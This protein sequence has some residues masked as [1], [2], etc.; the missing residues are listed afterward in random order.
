M[1]TT[2]QIKKVKLALFDFDGVF[3]DNYVYVNQDG[4]E[5]VRCNRSDG[6]GLARLRSLDIKS[7]IVS[8]E[9]NPVVSVRAKKLNI[10]CIQGVSDKSKAVL[11]ICNDCDINPEEALFVGNDINDL[12]ALKIVGLAVAV[13]DA[14]PEILP[15]VDYITEKNGGFGAV[16]EI[17][18]L[19]CDAKE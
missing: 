19:I 15:Y 14:Y 8:T 16:R 17:C 9:K 1:V 10:N 11:D 3:T 13:G 6:I 2:Q 4:S 18:D 5:M 12:S 7:Y